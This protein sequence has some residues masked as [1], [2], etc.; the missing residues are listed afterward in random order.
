MT[1]EE[2][3]PLF[4][5]LWEQEEIEAKIKKQWEA[6]MAPLREQAEEIVAKYQTG[7][8]AAKSRHKQLLDEILEKVT[9]EK[10]DKPSDKI[11]GCDERI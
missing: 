10:E 3:R 1:S 6:E 11:G 9:P 7:L 4:E 5:Q 2:I 8:E